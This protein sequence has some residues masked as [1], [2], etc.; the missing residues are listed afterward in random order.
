MRPYRT[1]GI[2][3]TIAQLQDIEEL[4]YTYATP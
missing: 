4:G 1:V 2:N 3:T